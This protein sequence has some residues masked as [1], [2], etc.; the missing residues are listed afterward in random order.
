LFFLYLWVAFTAAGGGIKTARE[1]ARIKIDGLRLADR[2]QP[3]V[4][5]NPSQGPTN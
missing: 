4:Q 1:V 2:R 3:K 5:P